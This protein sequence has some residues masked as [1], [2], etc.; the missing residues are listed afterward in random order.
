VSTDSRSLREGELFVALRGPRF[1]AHDHVGEAFG[2]G[3]WGAMVEERAWRDGKV[4]RQ[5][6]DFPG[7][8]IISVGDTA[9]ALGD[10]AAWYRSRLDLKVIGITGSNGKTTTKEMTA[11]IAGRRW[12]VHKTEGN[13]NNLIGL[14]LTVLGLDETHE[15]AVLEMGMNRRGE[16]RRLA[17]IARP[18]VGVVTN[19]GLAHLEHLGSIEAVA[20][21]KGELIETLG[22]GA[23]AVLNA[24]DRRVA[25][26]AVSFPGR[27]ITFGLGPGADFRALEIR[28]GEGGDSFTLSSP[29]GTRDISLPLPGEHNVR[30]AL[31][32]AAAAFA[33]GAGLDVIGEGLAA[34]RPVPMRFALHSYLD[35]IRVVNDAYNAN[36]DSM[37]SALRSLKMMQSRG[38]HAAVLGD[39]LELGEESPGAHRRLGKEAAAASLD[40]LVAVG[41]FAEETVRGA[42]E[43]GLPRERIVVVPDCRGA[44]EALGAWLG[45][46]DLV[47]LKGSRGVALEEVLGLL[48]SEGI[49]REN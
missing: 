6:S 35:G 49:L 33:L 48:E 37:E 13:F 12:K 31:A 11:S 28:G 36:P 39:M 5:V 23:T 19:A 26:L 29:L 4:N 27:V 9:R 22:P 41:R 21:A 44:A 14:P 45:P 25:A 8:A 34:V 43:A 47:L 32:A 42:V 3:A 17:Q 16:I 2:R 30:N 15:V 7:R 38:R 40:L 10:L 24:D 20:A 1:D 46:G 18:D